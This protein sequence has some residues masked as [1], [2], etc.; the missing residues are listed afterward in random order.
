MNNITDELI[1]TDEMINEYI[2]YM[3]NDIQKIKDILDAEKNKR[4]LRNKK[5]KR[6]L[7]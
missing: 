4:I 3:N 1:I 6:I 5:F 2:K 7:K